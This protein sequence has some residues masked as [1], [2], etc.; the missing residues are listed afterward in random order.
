M[1]TARALYL[2]RRREFGKIGFFDAALFGQDR[3]H[4]AFYPV[5]VAICNGDLPTAG[6]RHNPVK[7]MV[8][9]QCHSQGGEGS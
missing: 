2:P 4:F 3:G 6:R 7:I 5:G 9:F 1:Y 8:S